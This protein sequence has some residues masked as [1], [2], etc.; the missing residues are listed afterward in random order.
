[1]L[2]EFLQVPRVAY[3]S[4]EI[5]LRS[6]IQTYAGDLGVLAGDTPHSAADLRV[7]LVA[8]TRR[9]D[10]E[11]FTDP[12]RLASSAQVGSRPLPSHRDYVFTAV[13]YVHP[14]VWQEHPL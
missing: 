14:P 11:C 7:P 13:R 12:P 10:V 1:V 5:A 3:F 9:A 6:E 2:C 8:E 4:M